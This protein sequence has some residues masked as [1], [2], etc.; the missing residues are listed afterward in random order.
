MKHK[1]C[2]APACLACN[3]VARRKR[4]VLEIGATLAFIALLLAGWLRSR[5]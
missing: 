2:N 1:P 5:L 4:T 3:P